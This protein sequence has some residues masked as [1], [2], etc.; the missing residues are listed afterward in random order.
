MSCHLHGE[1]DCLCPAYLIVMGQMDMLMECEIEARETAK[2]GTD[3]HISPPVS[4][5]D[6]TLLPPIG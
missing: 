1:Y 6:D 4:H 3:A 2:I 5:P